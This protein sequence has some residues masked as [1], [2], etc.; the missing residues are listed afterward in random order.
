MCYETKKN[1]RSE[2]KN[3]SSG[4]HDFFSFVKTARGRI[5]RVGVDCARGLIIISGDRRAISI[6]QLPRTSADRLVA[7]ARLIILS[8]VGTMREMAVY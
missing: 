6:R 2:V 8:F 5:F 1:R 4:S 3:A 7:A